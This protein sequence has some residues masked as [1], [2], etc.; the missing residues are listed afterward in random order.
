MKTQSLTPISRS[1]LSTSPLPT[2]LSSTPILRYSLSLPTSP[3]RSRRM[4][5]YRNVF[6]IDIFLRGIYPSILQNYEINKNKKWQK[7]NN[8]YIRSP[9]FPPELKTLA[10]IFFLA[11]LMHFSRAVRGN[12]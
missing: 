11:Q 2:I 7:Y 3:F 5:P 1:T 9:L 6:E 10:F 12:I 4:Y 8:M